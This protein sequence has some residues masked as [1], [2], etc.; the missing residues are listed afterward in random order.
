MAKKQTAK[1]ALQ[2]EVNQSMAAKI[3]AAK[4]K[5]LKSQ[6]EKKKELDQ[7]FAK[8]ESAK[9]AIL[10]KSAP[11]KETKSQD[12]EDKLESAK[13]LIVEKEKQKADAKEQKVQASVQNE[14]SQPVSQISPHISLSQKISQRISQTT[15]N[16]STS[17]SNTIAKVFERKEQPKP[18]VPSPPK[19][20]KKQNTI[21]EFLTNF[22][23]IVTSKDHKPAV[24]KKSADAEFKRKLNA[25]IE[26]AG[27]SLS[28]REMFAKINK[29]S[30]V[31]C[32]LI[33]L[34]FIY[35]KYEGLGGIFYYISVLMFFAALVYPVG[36][37][38][39]SLLT[40]AFLDLRIAQRKDAVEKHFPE[41][42][43]VVAANIRAGMTIDQALWRGARPQFGI[44]SKEI[45]IIAKKA[46]VGQ[47]LSSALQDFGRKY[48]S[49]IIRRSVGLIVEGMDAGS[50]IGDLLEN[51]ALNL[52]DIDLRK[53]SMS[54]NVTSYVIFI[55]FAVVVAAPGL[56]AVATQ[57]LTIVQE[58]GAKMNA[59]QSAGSGGNAAG[60]SLSLSTDAVSQ[61]DFFIFCLVMLFL[62][63]TMS[64]IIISAIRTGK[65]F[66]SVRDMPIFWAISMTL[67]IVLRWVLN[68]LFSGVL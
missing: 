57:L 64:T 62:T 50:E 31:I 60:I 23:N 40:F 32:S 55:V 56:F 30:I 3:D 51:I 44:L 43:H 47:D 68:L 21:V 35:T 1:T 29:F 61:S 25:Y 67:F 38:V 4:Q 59:A 52:E 39:L 22:K 66:G 48:D 12:I 20:A 7:S 27:F 53:Q 15:Q 16:I 2:Q 33:Y 42:L 46:M 41:F 8:I 65:A 58:V 5:I 36:T 26:T 63:T 19:E 28:Y 17:L 14:Q 10:E 9:K 34:Y 6:T 54:A 11:V 37:F 49:K 13:R 24:H 18:Q 45:E